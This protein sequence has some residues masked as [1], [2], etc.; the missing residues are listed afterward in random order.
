MPE[1]IN[2][3]EVSKFLN[4][5]VRTEAEFLVLLRDRLTRY[6]DKW[7]VLCS[8]VDIPKETVII[9]DGRTDVS[10]LST[11]DI[12]AMVD[13]VTELK[14]ITEKEGASVKELSDVLARED[15]TAILAKT[16]VRSEKVIIS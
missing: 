11:T 7:D 10:M 4:E 15:T 8:L 13:L 1:I 2:D 16:I 3:F 5:S 6:T 12:R 9:D 14:A